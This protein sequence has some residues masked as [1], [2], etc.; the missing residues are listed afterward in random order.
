MELSVK[1][2]F[3]FNIVL[4]VFYKLIDRIKEVFDVSKGSEFIFEIDKIDI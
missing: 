2:I 3:P 4:N 1:R